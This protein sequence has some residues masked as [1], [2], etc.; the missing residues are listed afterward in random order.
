MAHCGEARQDAPVALGRVNVI[1]ECDNARLNILAGFAE[2][3]SVDAPKDATQIL[4][5][6]QV[7]SASCYFR[8][9]LDRFGAVEALATS[10]A[11]NH[12]KLVSQVGVFVKPMSIERLLVTETEFVLIRAADARYAK[13][14]DA[15]AI[16]SRQG[17][18]EKNWHRL[19]PFLEVPRQS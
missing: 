7:I 11:S 1:I 10:L 8:F 12:L 4:G 2:E 5:D 18:I 15:V 17:R 13:D 3:L 6:D 9:G 16:A 14:L 19:S